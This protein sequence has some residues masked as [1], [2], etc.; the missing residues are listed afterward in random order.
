MCGVWTW[1]ATATGPPW[2]TPTRRCAKTMRADFASPS[3]MRS[4]RRPVRCTPHLCTDV[5][6]RPMQCGGHHSGW[7]ARCGSKP[8]VR[9]RWR[10]SRSIAPMHSRW[11]R[12]SASR[13]VRAWG[14]PTC[15]TSPSTKSPVRVPK[16]GCP[17]CSP[18]GCPRWG[19]SCSPP[20]STRPVVSRASSR[21]HG[22]QNSGSSCSGPTPP[23][24]TTAAGS[25]PICP[26]MVQCSST[27]AACHSPACRWPGPMPAR[28]CSP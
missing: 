28:C 7:K 17:A 2:D 21:W 25:W 24:S 1:P 12:R 26:P 19:V 27:S 9:K 16:R 18:T 8:P 4:W 13:S 11:W 5:S 23:R 10:T 22:W 14:S 15:P 20:C 3:P 6:A